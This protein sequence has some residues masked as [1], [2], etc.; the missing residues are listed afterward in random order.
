ML[1]HSDV[2][3][4]AESFLTLG[5]DDLCVELST[6]QQKRRQRGGASRVSTDDPT[7]VEKAFEM[8]VRRGLQVDVNEAPLSSS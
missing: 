8:L 4:E 3:Q 2:S 1:V 7:T 5:C 6:T